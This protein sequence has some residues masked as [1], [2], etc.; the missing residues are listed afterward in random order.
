MLEMYFA[1]T[2]INISRAA[3]WRNNNFFS[4]VVNSDPPIKFGV[5]IVSTMNVM[6][7]AVIR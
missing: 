7:F 3:F 5:I 4:T 1:G 2:I 6:G